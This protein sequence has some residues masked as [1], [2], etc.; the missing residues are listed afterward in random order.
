[1]FKDHLPS[2]EV[3]TKESNHYALQQTISVLETGCLCGQPST[4][5][6]EPTQKL[7]Q[8]NVTCQVQC[9]L[10]LALSPWQVSDWEC[11]KMGLHLTISLHTIQ[12]SATI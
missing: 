9:E 10:S 11:P 8:S 2:F 4:W 5:S 12:S 1:M 6:M 3:S 7:C